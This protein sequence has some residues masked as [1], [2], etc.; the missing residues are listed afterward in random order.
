MS[1]VDLHPRPQPVVS[2]DNTT[3]RLVAMI[4]QTNLAALDKT[5]SHIRLGPRTGFSLA[6]VRTGSIGERMTRVCAEVRMTLPK[7]PRV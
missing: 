6:A 4:G 3:E 7:D 1:V 2:V 5:L